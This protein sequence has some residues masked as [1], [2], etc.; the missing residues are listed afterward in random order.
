MSYPA[1]LTLDASPEIDRWRPLVQWL[2]ALPHLL[3]AGALSYVAGAVGVISWFVI[4]F[5]G[6]LP[7]GLANFQCLFIR[8]SA[9][10]YSYSGWL[11]E[12]YPPFEFEMTGEDPDTDPL[13]VELA[14]E[15]EG[16]N[17]LTVGLRFIWI[18][19]AAFYAFILLIA[20]WFAYIASFFVVLFTGRWSDGMRE[21]V[22][23]C[24]RYLIWFNAYAYL[25]TDDYPPFT[26]DV[27]TPAR[28]NPAA[29]DLPSAPA[30]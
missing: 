11:R 29:G 14:P 28:D 5:T 7:A 3:I 15:L 17:R 18:I 21:F 13:K 12:E 24:A 30:V 22:L 19:P 20:L 4:L 6:T 23:K 2:L 8:Y 10:V 25:L 27:I 26:F 1:D 16:R 9:R